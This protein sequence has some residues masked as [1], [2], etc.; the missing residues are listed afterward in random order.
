MLDAIRTCLVVA[1]GKRGRQGSLSD[2]HAMCV[3]AGSGEVQGTRA[4]EGSGTNR[5]RRG[6]NRWQILAPSDGCERPPHGPS[7]TP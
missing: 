3:H 2:A 6:P 4:K 1:Q 5:V 7:T